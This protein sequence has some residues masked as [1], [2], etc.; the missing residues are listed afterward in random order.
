[1]ATKDSSLEILLDQALKYRDKAE[2]EEWLRTVLGDD[3][4]KLRELKELIDHH[5]DGSWMDPTPIAVVA[6]RKLI[7]DIAG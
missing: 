3:P 4:E 1:M 2:R 7:E 5:Q 6:A